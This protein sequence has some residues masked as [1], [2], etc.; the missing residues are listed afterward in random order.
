MRQV[1]S[2]LRLDLAQ[3]RELYAFTQYGSEID[4]AAQQQLNRGKR[5]VE[6]LKQ[7]QYDVMNLA[8]KVVIIYAGIK[9]LIDDVEVGSL[10]EFEK[11]LYNYLEKQHPAVIAE[12][13]EKKVLSDALSQA[14]S[15][16]ITAFKE[17]FKMVKA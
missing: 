15:A 6:I 3:Y 8:H 2:Q 17:E 11:K 14:L 10:R 9:G 12:I 5:M 7:D 4:K 13:E 16:A 1:A